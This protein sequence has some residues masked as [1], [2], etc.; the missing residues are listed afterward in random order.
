MIALLASDTR[1]P[2][3]IAPPLVSARSY[4]EGFGSS[5]PPLEARDI[6]CGQVEGRLPARDQL[7]DMLTD[8]RR[9]LEA[10]AGE[11]RR[12]EEP[13]GLRR[14]PDERVPIRADLVVAPPG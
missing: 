5:Q 9:L 7:R 14:L 12:V 10:V 2:S 8:R 13:F 1:R 4:D 6:E 11:P 3:V